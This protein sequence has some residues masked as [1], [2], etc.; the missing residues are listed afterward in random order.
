LSLSAAASF[1]E[2]TEAT[3]AIAANPSNAKAYLKR[4]NVYLD[5]ADLDEDAN[6]RNADID[7]AIKDFSR[8]IE[9][10]PNLANAYFS[11]GAA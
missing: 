5:F 7:R 2:V 4:G 11:R 9:L 8:A 10:Q 3:K 1:P 6:E